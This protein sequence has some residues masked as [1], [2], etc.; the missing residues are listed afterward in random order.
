VAGAPVGLDKTNIL[1]F[2][3]D[4]G[5]VLDEQTIPQTGRWCV[6]PPLF[7]GMLKKSDLKDASMTGD[8]QSV[9]R[10]GRLGTINQLTLY[11]SNQIATTADAS[12]VT[13]HNI[14]AGTRHAITFASQ[15]LN[16][17]TIPNPSDFGDLLRGLQVYGF[18]VIKEEAL[19]HGYIFKQ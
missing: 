8:S 12:G 17:E 14:I 2:L 18:K 4:I 3:V 15:L 16:T 1:D 5:T 9:L 19:V 6:L 11:S 10:N 7:C 13:A